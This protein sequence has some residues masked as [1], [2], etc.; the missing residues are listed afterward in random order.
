MKPEGLLVHSQVPYSE[1]D[2]SSPCPHITLPEDTLLLLL[3]SSSSSSHLR[4]GL[5]SGLFP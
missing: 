3:L 2:Q 5:P 1:P 4:L